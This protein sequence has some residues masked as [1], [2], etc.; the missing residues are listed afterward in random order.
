[1]VHQSKEACFLPRERYVSY[2]LANFH[3]LFNKG[4]RK[5]VSTLSAEEYTQTKAEMTSELQLLEA[6]ASAN[7]SL[8]SELAMA[9][10]PSITRLNILNSNISAYENS[11]DLVASSVVAPRWQR[12]M[13]GG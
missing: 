12:P 10:R 8:P 2:S 13:M 7:A 3:E 9:M 11:W 5:E 6:T 4:K 1:M